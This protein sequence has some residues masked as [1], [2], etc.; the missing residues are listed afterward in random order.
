MVMNNQKQLEL[1][2]LSGLHIGAV[3]PL[4]ADE[5][6]IGCNDNCDIVLLDVGVLPQHYTLTIK[7]GQWMHDENPVPLKKSIQIGGATLGIFESDDSSWET[8]AIEQD[9]L[10]SDNSVPPVKKKHYWLI[11]AGFAIIVLILSITYVLDDMDAEAST[12]LKEETSQLAEDKSPK[13][14]KFE[15][16]KILSERDLA[17]YVDVLVEDNK[18]IFSGELTD[19]EMTRFDAAVLNLKRRVGPAIQIESD[20]KKIDLFLPFEIIEIVKGSV[21]SIKLA[22]GI[23]VYEGET[24]NDVQLVAIER[25][26]LIFSG[27][28]TFEIT[29]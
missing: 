1:R 6:T 17:S 10:P 20:I 16:T 5:I 7:D 8:D 19:T 13:V 11:G 18:I 12:R 4:V 25:G 28:R 24:V 23:R 27:K 2:V 29:W 14:L 15:A 21:S 26:K 9:N 3:L 22:N